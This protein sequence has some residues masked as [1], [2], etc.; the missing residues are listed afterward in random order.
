M[1]VYMI[2]LCDN[3]YKTS[4]GRQTTTNSAQKGACRS[5]EM[6]TY[7]V[8]PNLRLYH[9]ILARSSC[10]QPLHPGR[11]CH[12]LCAFPWLFDAIF[13][14]RCRRF[15][16]AES[17]PELLARIITILLARKWPDGSLDWPATIIHKVFIQDPCFESRSN[18]A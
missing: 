8:S 1:Y 18:T 15:N 7:T 14:S 10:K 3:L 9:L 11:P 13:S 12:P 2:F 17:K 4:A 5:S 6:I 16:T